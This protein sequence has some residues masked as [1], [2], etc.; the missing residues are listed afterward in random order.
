MTDP[1]QFNEVYLCSRPQGLADACLFGFRSGALAPLQDGE[2]QVQSLYWACDPGLRH[3]LSS[4]DNYARPIAINERITGFSVGR[5]TASRSA[6]LPVGEVVVG[7]WGWCDYV[8]LASAT[9]ERA[10]H[11]A[12]HPAYA[13]LS[14]LGIPGATAYFGMKEVGQLRAGDNVFITSAAGAVGSIACQL[15]KAEGARVVGLAGGPEKCSWLRSL[16]VDE[17]IDYQCGADIA[18]SLAS[19][20]P[21]GIDLFFDTLGNYIIDTALPYMAVKGRV[22]VCGNTVDANIPLDE[23]YGVR[24]LRALIAKRLRVE[25][26]LVL[27][28]KPRF[29][30]A[31][32]FLRAMT[33]AGQLSC[34]HALDRGL[35][36]LPFVFCSLFTENQLGRKIVASE[37]QLIE[38][39]G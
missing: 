30:E 4:S 27:D 32:D 20:F 18:A 13:L 3:R 38:R 26:F 25:G 19:A 1:L 37:I 14:Y 22:V 5:V 15:A 36:R 35:T 11:F 10:C 29:H 2:V 31:W 7:N 21:Q 17:V 28:Y 24:N 8:H 23:R 6:S 12:G 34:L 16:G 9:V 39:G 33:D